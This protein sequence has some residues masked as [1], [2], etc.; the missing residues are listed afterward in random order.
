MSNFGEVLPKRTVFLKNGICDDNALKC[1][2]VL[3]KV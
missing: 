1:D 3:E 2:L